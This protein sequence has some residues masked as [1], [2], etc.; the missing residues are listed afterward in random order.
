M[1]GQRVVV[2][3]E[4]VVELE[5]FSLPEPGAGEVLIK[6]RTSLVSPGTERAFYLGLPNTNATYPL[7][8]GYSNIGEVIAVGAGVEAVQVGDRVA[9][10]THHASHVIAPADKCVPV[11]DDLPDKVAVFFNLAAIAMQGVRKT[12][13]ELGER[14]V[15]IGVGPIGIFAVQLVRQNGAVPAVAIDVDAE[16][17]ALAKQV[18]ADYAL[19]NDESLPEQI[20]AITHGKGFNVV[21][22]ST[23]SDKVIT[24]AFQMA[25]V[26]GRVSLLGSARGEA[27]NINFYRDVHRKG[28][29]IIGAHEIT[30]PLHESLPGWW[31]QVDEQYTA[32]QMFALG[33]LQ[34]EPLISHRFSWEEFPQAYALLKAWDQT[35]TGMLIHW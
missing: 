8:P 2:V 28:L 33:R 10:G 25:A 35:T 34:A 22:E 20:N 7:Y 32:L 9:S 23:G 6:T 14:A 18:G 1:E 19:L 30:R 12:R 17:L 27:N 11:P 4:G 24:Q 13:I 29:N 5:A 15:V 3:R 26:R 31:T 16:R 21:I